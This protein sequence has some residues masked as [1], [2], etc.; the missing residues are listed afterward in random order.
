MI[1]EVLCRELFSFAGIEVLEIVIVTASE[2]FAE[3]WNHAA[4]VPYRPLVPGRYFGSLYRD[5]VMNG[6]P[7][8]LEYLLDPESLVTLWV[9]DTLVC[10]IDRNNEGNMLLKVGKGKKL[11]LIA[12]DQ[13]DCFCGS[14]AM[15]S[16]E[17][18]GRFLNRPASECKFAIDAVGLSGG[19]SA[20]RRA[21]RRAEQSLAQFD[22]AANEI[23]G[24][25]WR[26]SGLDPGRIQRKLN[27]RVNRLPQIL[28]LEQF[29]ELNLGQYGDIPII[30]GES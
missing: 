18:E 21:I 3:S 23:P 8:K 29:P 27:E 5:D 14:E 19:L 13:S 20:L 25:W 6:P 7:E 4:S 12:A 22:A 11:G 2:N 10:N 30:G 24:E 1:S 17:W 16:G 28:P 15:A 26:Q 9:M